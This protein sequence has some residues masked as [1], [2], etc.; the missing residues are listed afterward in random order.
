M[1]IIYFPQLKNR[2]FNMNPIFC[3]K[4]K[5]Y[6]ELFANTDVSEIQFKHKDVTIAIT[7]STIGD[8]FYV[9][10]LGLTRS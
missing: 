10:V 9:D 2:G 1:K 3:E 5:N 7:R 6:I 4:V 8:S